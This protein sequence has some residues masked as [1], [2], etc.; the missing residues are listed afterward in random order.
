MTDAHATIASIVY[1]PLSVKSTSK[2]KYDRVATGRAELIAGHGI[3]G[4]KKAGKN[5]ERHLN[6]MSRE[7]LDQL[8][9]EGYDVA[10]GHMGEQI[11]VSGLDVNTLQAGDLIHLGNGAVAKV[12]KPR[13]GCAKFKTVQGHDP[14]EAAGRLGVMA[15]VVASGSIAVGDPV[16][17]ASAEAVN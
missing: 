9:A 12:S 5:P 10:P 15:T 4:D 7:V 14:S 1:T 13:T 16:R 2:D 3:D 17:A 8:A 11:I 6:I